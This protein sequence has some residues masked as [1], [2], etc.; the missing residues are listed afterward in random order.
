MKPRRGDDATGFDSSGKASSSPRRA[1]QA[2]R[3]AP[4][5]RRGVALE[6]VAQSQ[7]VLRERA[8]RPARAARSEAARQDAA[9]VRPARPDLSQPQ[10][11]LGQETPQE[12]QPNLPAPSLPTSIAAWLSRFFKSRPIQVLWR[13]IQALIVVSATGILVATFF[14]SVLQVRGTSMEPTVKEGDVVIADHSKKFATGDVIAFYYNNKVILKRVIA[15]PTDW[16]DIKPDGTVWV[17]GEELQEDY[18]Q[19]LSLGHPDIIFPYQVPEGRYFVLGDHRSASIDSRSS[20]IGT[21]SDDQVIGSVFLKVWP[22]K[23]LG[24]VR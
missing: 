2:I 17:N 5:A 1:L 10:Q 9:R 8:G 20:T 22:L 13:V 19:G 11:A 21:V 3:P 15:F 24:T 14:I 12:A 6:D 4:A 23:N 18:V 16:V 7:S